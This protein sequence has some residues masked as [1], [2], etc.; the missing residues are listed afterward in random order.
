MEGRAGGVRHVPG[1]DTMPSAQPHFEP[2]ISTFRIRILGGAYCPPDL[3]PVWREIEIAANQT[4]AD[5]GNA[6]PRAFLFE[7]EHLWSF[8]LSGQPWD[9]ETEYAKDADP[10]VFGDDAPKAAAE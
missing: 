10:D 7:A 4:L 3:A 9:R 6:I 8:F 1:E 2:P 5:L